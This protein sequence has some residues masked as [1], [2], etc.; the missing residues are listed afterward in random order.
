MP[1]Q[2]SE[3]AGQWDETP[4][5]IKLARDVY[6]AICAKVALHPGAH[7][8]DFGGGTGLLTLKFIKD[9]DRITVV[10]TSAAMLDELRAKIEARQLTRIDI[11]QKEL[12]AAPLPANSCDIIISMMTLHHIAD[13]AALLRSFA[14]ILV[15]K[16]QVT[17]VDLAREE[18]DFH[19]P[20][21][22]YIHDGFE[23][24]DLIALL[25][26]A[27]FVDVAVE[28]VTSIARQTEAGDTKNFPVLLAS[29]TK[30]K[31]R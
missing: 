30:P 11:I 22:H 6:A 5:K 1:D 17:L 21:A 26:K 29:A 31:S 15:P 7:L 24:A 23:P 3:K 16:G 12:A 2:Y 19:P 8:V 14:A 20:G 13:L 18:G 27:G 9:V 10:D 4:W 28:A 25:E